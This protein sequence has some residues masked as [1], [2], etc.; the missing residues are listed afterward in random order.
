[1]SDEQWVVLF[2]RVGDKVFLVRRNV[3]FQAQ[4]DLPV[5]RAVETSYTDSILFALRIRTIN[6]MRQ[7]VVIDLSD[8]FLTN[9][10]NLPYGQLEPSR[11]I[12]HK[13]KAF[14]RNLELQVSATFSGRGRSNGVIDARGNTVIVHYGL[15]ELPDTLYA[16]RF[17]DD[18]VG[19]FL[20]V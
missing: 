3:R 11:T 20:T 9:F 14:P 18:R 12:W 8:I 7:T 4:R 13:V 1:N 2:K 10:A 15:V 19:H 17:A 6:P 16:P 5:N